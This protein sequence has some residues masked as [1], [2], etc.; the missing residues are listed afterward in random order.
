MRKSL[1]YREYLKAKS[2][3][4]RKA[5]MLA[6]YRDIRSILCRLIKRDTQVLPA[7]LPA[8]SD[9]KFRIICLEGGSPLAQ[10]P[11]IYNTSS[12]SYIVLSNRLFS[13]FLAR[14]PCT[15]R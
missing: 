12:F 5:L 1:K 6:V 4:F 14:V 2:A 3:R 7:S 8:I 13:H 10:S 15:P 9:A 11:S